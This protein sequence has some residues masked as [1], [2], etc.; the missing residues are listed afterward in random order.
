MGHRT[1]T[2]SRRQQTR[3][4]GTQGS[5]LGWITRVVWGGGSDPSARGGSAKAR[6]SSC[7]HC[8]RPVPRGSTRCQ[9]CG[10]RTA[11][12]N[13]NALAIQR[14]KGRSLSEVQRKI[15]VATFTAEERRIYVLGV[16][17]PHEGEVKAGGQR[18]Y[19]NEAIAAVEH[20]MRDGYVFPVDEGCL[21]LTREGR[22]TANHLAGS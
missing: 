10:A 16:N 17:G 1:V 2:S 15:L 13:D 20:L 7:G 14:S 4:A 11:I 12:P 21:A 3:H 5:A 19:G 9:F 8:D 22:R 18:L 6:A